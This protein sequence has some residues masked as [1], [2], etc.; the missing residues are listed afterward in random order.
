MNV[1]KD[2]F[3]HRQ[4]Q[5]D[6]GLEKF[7]DTVCQSNLLEV[8]SRTI[9]DGRVIS[10]IHN[11]VHKEETISQ[12]EQRENESGLYKQRKISGLFVL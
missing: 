6:M 3:K 5:V 10:L 12:S 8:L 11:S 7:F 4:P 1:T 2:K 9:Q